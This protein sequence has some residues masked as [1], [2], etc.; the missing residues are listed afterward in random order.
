MILLPYIELFRKSFNF[1]DFIFLRRT[2]LNPLKAI[3]VCDTLK[4]LSLLKENHTEHDQL[5]MKAKINFYT[6]EV[7]QHENVLRFVGAV[8]SDSDIGPFIIYEYCSNG[9]MRDYLH[10]LKNNVSVETHEQLL[11]FGLGIARGMDYLALKKIVHRRLAARNILLDSEF[12]P[13]ISGFGPQ[14][15]ETKDDDG[16]A[17]KRERIPLKWMAPECLKSTECATEKSDVWSFGVVLWEIF[18][19]GDSPYENIRGRNLP[20][21]LKGGYRLPKPEQCDDRWYA[22]MKQAWEEDPKKRPTFKEIRN[23]LDEIFVA[24]PT[25]DYYYYRL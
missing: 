13:K 15:D 16:Q 18:S 3:I 23:I 22:V 8:I 20:V 4:E 10:T 7:G 6:I 1:K 14:P 21:K 9:P 17:N 25:D 12:V 19:F 24:A 5:L 11:R 2:T